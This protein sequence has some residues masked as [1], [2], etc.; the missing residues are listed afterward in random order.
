MSGSSPPQ[1]SGFPRWALVRRCAL[2]LYLVILVAWSATYG[3]PVQRE[4]VI[5]W[6]CGALVCVSI[7]RDPRLILQLV[8]D[9]MPIVLVLLAYDFSRGA[10]DSSGS[11]PTSTR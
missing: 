4:L 7:G 11:A 9:W 3:V 10:A 8:V 5:A 1:G 2:A 6:V